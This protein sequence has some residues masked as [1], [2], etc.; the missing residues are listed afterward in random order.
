MASKP[1]QDGVKP[2]SK[3]PNTLAPKI[4]VKRPCRVEKKAKKQARQE[5][6]K[7]KVSYVAKPHAVVATIVGR[8]VAPR[9]GATHIVSVTDD[10]Q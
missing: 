4:A 1:L 6:L 8:H 5:F 2:A 7:C 9:G 10:A 3:A